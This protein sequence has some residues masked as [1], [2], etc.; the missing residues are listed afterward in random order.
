M[1]LK[2]GLS[3]MLSGLTSGLRLSVLLGVS[4]G[5]VA[6]LLKQSTAQLLL[7][8]TVSACAAI[9]A[10]FLS[11]SRGKQ[12]AI[13]TGY[14]YFKSLFWVGSVFVTSMVT[15]ALRLFAASPD[16]ATAW[17]LGTYLVAFWITS[18]LRKYGFEEGAPRPRRSNGTPRFDR[19]V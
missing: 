7:T 14:Y 10:G 6:P 15:S 9:L 17:V 19:W 5:V 8:W 1:S 3:Q 11:A 18:K 2:Q 12:F 4:V 16:R 13:N